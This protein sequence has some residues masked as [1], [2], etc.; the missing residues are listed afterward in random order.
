MKGCSIPTFGHLSTMA[1]FGWFDPTATSPV[2][3][4]MQTLSPAI[5]TASFDR[6]C[7]SWRASLVRTPANTMPRCG[8]ASKG[9]RSRRSPRPDGLRS[10]QQPYPLLQTSRSSPSLP[11]LEPLAVVLA[12]HL[13]PFRTLGA[14]AHRLL[15]CGRAV[16][17]AALRIFCRCRLTRSRAV[18]CAVGGCCCVAVPVAPVC[19]VAATVGPEPVS[20]LNTWTRMSYVV[21]MHKAMQEPKASFVD[22]CEPS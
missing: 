13:G 1:G 3:P 6:A 14:R 17:A 15:S 18:H 9:S 10:D 11:E 19:A 8:R 21:V 5:S 2:R 22:P 16:L 7:S 12:A 20:V 4:A